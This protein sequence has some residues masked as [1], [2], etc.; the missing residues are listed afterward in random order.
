MGKAID[1]TQLLLTASRECWLALN[2]EQTTIVGRGETIK[3]AVEEAKKKGVD[4][5]IV[6][7]SPKTWTPRVFTEVR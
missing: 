6:M 4:D 2:E 5:P 3:E 7:W 1:L